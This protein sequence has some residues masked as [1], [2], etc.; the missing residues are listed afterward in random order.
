LRSIDH[1]RLRGHSCLRCRPR[2][3]TMFMRFFS[4][5]ALSFSLTAISH[6]QEP[7]SQLPRTRIS[8]GMYQ[9]DAQVA[10]S[11]KEREIGLMYR[12]EMPPT[13]GMVFVF[14]QPATQCFW[15][16]WA[17]DCNYVRP[18]VAT[19]YQPPPPYYPYYPQP[20]AGTSN[21]E[22]TGYKPPWDPSLAG[23]RASGGS[24]R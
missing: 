8:A 16:G 5:L 9:I 10:Q 11:P 2:K 6:A 15:N 23:T 1:A 14:E 4:L 22:I 18:P 24:G 21:P 19:Y 17:W 3:S 12:K 13:E 7:Q 20:S